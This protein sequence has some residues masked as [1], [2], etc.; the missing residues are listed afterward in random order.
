MRKA[1][2]ILS[3]AEHDDNARMR[4]GFCWD[5]EIG[6]ILILFKQFVK[7]V[8]KVASPEWM[9]VP[10]IPTERIEIILEEFL[11]FLYW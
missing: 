3:A 9:I 10:N 7:P 2:F 6:T 5:F 11:Q 4:K 1:H 8:L